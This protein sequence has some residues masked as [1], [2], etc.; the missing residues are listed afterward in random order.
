MLH[1]VDRQGVRL[2][3]SLE[4]A[5][6]AERAATEFWKGWLW[7]A[8]CERSQCSSMLSENLAARFSV[9][10]EEIVREWTEWYELLTSWDLAAA[11]TGRD[12]RAA[13]VT[14]GE[15]HWRAR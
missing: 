12:V 15:T 14:Y 2:E 7:H 1:A 3:L 5:Q 9:A 4:I 10:A 11:L 8:R 6:D 13:T